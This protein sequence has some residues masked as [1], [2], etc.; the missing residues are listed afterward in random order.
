MRRE[1]EA[2]IIATAEAG[3]GGAIRNGNAWDDFQESYA[4]DAVYDL[5][6]V[7]RVNCL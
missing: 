3:A 5:Y 4:R 7:G 6:K 1:G 2:D